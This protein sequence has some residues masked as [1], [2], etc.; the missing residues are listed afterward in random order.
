[1]LQPPNRFISAPRKYR[2]AAGR[3]SGRRYV[4]YHL[5]EPASRSVACS[6]GWLAS[7]TILMVLAACGQ[8][9]YLYG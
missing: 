2:R 3:H 8:V 5:L 4:D 1:M 6:K 7:P 9:L